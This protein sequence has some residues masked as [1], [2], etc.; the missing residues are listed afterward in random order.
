MAKKR[1]ASSA[2]ARRAAGSARRI[3][4]AQIDFSD[5]PESTDAELKRARRVGRPK[6]PYAKQ[7]IAIRIDPRLLARLR[8]L[9]RRRQ[10]PY[11]TMIHELLE[12]AAKA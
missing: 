8:R 7:L 9:A 3:A 1:S 11:Q 10:K 4:D 6:S 5:I 12:H 2:R